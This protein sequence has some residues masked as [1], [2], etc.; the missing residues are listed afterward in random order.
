MELLMIAIGWKFEMIVR[1]T[2]NSFALTKT[3][4]WTIMSG[5]TFASQV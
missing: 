2:K 1:T 5:T 3:F 4:G